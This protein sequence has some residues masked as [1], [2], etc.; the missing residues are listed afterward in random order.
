[1]E[2]RGAARTIVVRADSHTYMYGAGVCHRNRSTDMG[3]A[4]KFGALYFRIAPRHKGH[5][6][7]IVCR[8]VGAK[9]TILAI[10]KDLSFDGATYKSLEFLQVRP[11]GIWRWPE[12]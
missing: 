3:F 9:T 8:K 5:S 12:G 2:K 7:R 4:L 1:M 10:A 11:S 6:E